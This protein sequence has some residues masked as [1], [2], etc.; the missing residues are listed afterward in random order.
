MEICLYDQPPQSPRVRPRSPG[1][2]ATLKTD[3]KLRIL[4]CPNQPGPVQSSPVRDPVDC[5]PCPCPSSILPSRRLF[6]QPLFHPP[7]TPFAA[8]NLW[9][10]STFAS[11]PTSATR[12]PVPAPVQH[13]VA[14]RPQG[15]RAVHV[16]FHLRD[17]SSRPVV[18]SSTTLRPPSRL[19]LGA[20]RPSLGNSK[21]SPTTS[22]NPIDSAHDDL[23]SF[24]VTRRCAVRCLSSGRLGNDATS[25]TWF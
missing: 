20:P 12:L 7:K 11:A 1:A 25:Q 8:T 17:R 19:P 4:S 24:A 16:H 21:R 6:L 10:L 23:Q 9:P 13:A 18:A 2:A 5:S 22:A 15:T 14:F 3:C